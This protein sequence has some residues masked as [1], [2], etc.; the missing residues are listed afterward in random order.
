MQKVEFPD[1]CMV[2]HKVTQLYVGFAVFHAVNFLT[3]FNLNVKKWLYD[4]YHLLY[5]NFC[6]ELILI[7]E[8]LKY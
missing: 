8:L 3:H 7:R 6:L 5:Q 4:V 2:S 1:T